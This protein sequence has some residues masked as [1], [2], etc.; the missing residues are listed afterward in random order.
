MGV[1][2]VRHLTSADFDDSYGIIAAV[3][4][5][6]HREFFQSCLW[7]VNA[8]LNLFNSTLNKNE[9]ISLATHNASLK[10]K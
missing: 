2:C 5:I 10:I 1:C 9:Q 3:V 8:K 7:L 4:K 6:R